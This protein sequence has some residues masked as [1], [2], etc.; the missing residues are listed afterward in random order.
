MGGK[1]GSD[2]CKRTRADVITTDVDMDSVIK[3]GFENVNIISLGK[4][5]KVPPLKQIDA[6]FKFA[7][8]DFSKNYDFF[9]FS[10]NWA[11]FAAKKHKPNVYYCH[12]PTRAFY[13]LYKVYRE[14]QSLFVSLPFVIWVR[15]HRKISEYYLTHVSNIVT[16]SMNTQ[17]GYKSTLAEFGHCASAGR[18][19]KV[20]I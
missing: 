16:N 20:R 2:T 10:G 18:Y 15:I 17:S 6:S 8:C 7:S 5:L 14:N 13:D 19:F 1:T 3:M 12:T 4:T 9:I 11:F